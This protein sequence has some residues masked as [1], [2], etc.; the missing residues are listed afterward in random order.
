MQPTC[1]LLIELEPERIP[2]SDGD[3]APNV[4]L[5]SPIKPNPFANAFALMDF[6]CL[7][8]SSQESEEEV[9]DVGNKPC[10]DA[11]LSLELGDVQ[12]QDLE[13]EPSADAH[14]LRTPK[15]LAGAWTPTSL[16]YDLTPK[17]PA[18]TFGT[19]LANPAQPL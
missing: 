8:E 10:F 18:S 16:G 19:K 7:S 17:N 14:Q 13:D 12:E 9:S 6:D 15:N 2:A 5:R 3:R 11:K 1:R 4:I